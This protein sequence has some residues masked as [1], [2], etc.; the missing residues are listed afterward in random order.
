MPLHVSPL[1]M[2][3]GIVHALFVLCLR[4]NGRGDVPV[5]FRLSVHSRC[6]PLAPVELHRPPLLQMELDVGIHN[7]HRGERLFNDEL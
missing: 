1:G 5:P 7:W 6:S 2:T 3:T 4:R